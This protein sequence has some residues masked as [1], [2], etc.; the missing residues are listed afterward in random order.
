MDAHHSSSL[1]FAPGGVH[2]D[3]LTNDPDFIRIQQFVTDRTN[4]TEDGGADAS[5]TI[6]ED[7][8]NRYCTLYTLLHL[9][10]HSCLCMVRCTC[11]C[12]HVYINLHCSLYFY[13]YVHVYLCTVH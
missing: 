1:S 13:I 12:L 7:E 8:L 4:A 11:A 3:A 2:T 9:C 6:P 10:K 5:N